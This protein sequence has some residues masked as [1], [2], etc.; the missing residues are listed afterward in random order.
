[1][2]DLHLAWRLLRR[3]YRSGELR[4]LAAS[5]IVAV[6]AMS[7][8]GFVADRVRLGLEH[9]ARQLLGGDLQLTADH[10]WR[11]SLIDLARRDGLTVA[12]TLRFPSMASAGDG[13][14]WRTELAEIKAVTP[15]YPLRGQLRV[16][17]GINRPDAVAAAAPTAGT[18]WLDERL[19]TGLKSGVG[20]TVNVGRLP[21]R[22]AAI[23]TFEP[24]HGMSLF[25]L[26]PRLMMN[27]SDMDST[28]LVQPGSRISYGLLLAGADRDLLRFRRE[29]EKE[30]GRGEHLADAAD[31]NPQLRKGLQQARAYLGLSAALTVVLAAV[32]VALAARRYV[33]RRLDACAVMRCLGASQATLLR[34]HLGQ[35]LLLGFLASLVGVLTG[36]TLHFALLAALADTIGDGLPAPSWLPAGQGMAA[37]MLVLV[38]FALPAVVEI[39]RVPTLRVLRRELDAP[40]QARL[41]TH[42]IGPIALAGLLY[43]IAGDVKLGSYVVGGLGAAMLVFGLATWLILK[44]VDR[45]R[46]SVSLGEFAWRH[47]IAALARRASASALQISALALGFSALLLLAVTR[48][49]LLDAWNRSVPPGAPNRFVINI[50]GD[51]LAALRSFFEAAGVKAELAPMVR[52]R[53]VAIDGKPVSSTDFVEDRAKRLVEREFN[54]SWRADLPPGNKVESGRWFDTQDASRNVVS[55]ESGLAKTLGLHVGERIQFT[56]GGQTAEFTIVG[57]RKLDWESMRVN[58]FVLAPPGALERFAAS[59]IT[60]FHLARHDARVVE[61]L[62]RRFPNLTIIDVGAVLAQVEDQIARI[63]TAVELVFLLTVAAGL[64]VLYA[65]FSAYIDEREREIALMRALGARQQQIRR[66]LMVEFG[67]IGGIAGGLAALA[68]MAI[69]EALARNVFELDLRANPYQVPLAMIGGAG[70]SLLVGW[71]AVRPLLRIPA[72]AA[73]RRAN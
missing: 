12:Q 13:D 64:I 8:V 11:P 37:G 72:V 42:G 53:L 20:D 17:P 24:D 57:T 16:A 2:R 73:L 71:L 6:A 51:Q 50:Q 44:L 55:I 33:D 19:A 23:L 32:A 69:G 1:M 35:L 47:G 22:V 31:G 18:V 66:A 7:A 4:L 9:N 59:Y 65:A 70:L 52:G 36:F 34:L 15:N 14:S 58:F 26:A 30:L 41:L 49:E 5:L 67:L 28:G 38:A 48:G 45:L 60:S 46:R 43:W 29:A 10:P 54:L 3:D 56:I 21:L 27:L 39:R 61:D 40:P 68:A 63:A 62:V 25:S